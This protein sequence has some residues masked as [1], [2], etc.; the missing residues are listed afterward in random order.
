M[1]TKKKKKRVLILLLLLLLIG[2]AAVLLTL[3]WDNWFGDSEPVGG[4]PASTASGSAENTGSDPAS[5]ASDPKTP[6]LDP[7]AKDKDDTPSKAQSSEGGIAIPGF[8][9]VYLKAG[10]KEQKVSL[11]NPAANRCYFVMTLMLKDGTVLYKS[12]MVEPGK[13][14][15]D[16]T[17]NKAL[18]KGVYEDCVLKYETY[19]MDSTLSPLNGMDTKLTI[20]VK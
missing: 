2:A 3:N 20:E 18:D 17:M 7:N 14:I 13:G 11:E 16:I 1:E 9:T 12:K 10:V 5:T 19:S 4:N 6:D 8:K 15:Y